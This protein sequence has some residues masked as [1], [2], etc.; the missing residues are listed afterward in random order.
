MSDADQPTEQPLVGNGSDEPGL[1]WGSRKARLALTATILGSGLAFLDGS[2]VSVALPFIERDLGG[3]LATLQWIFD[4]YL[5][6][7]GSLVL[8]GGSLGDLLGKRRI[9]V[10]GTIGFGITS[11]M[12]GLAP[13]AFALVVARML[14]GVAAALLVP[15]SL[16]ILNSVF[17]GPNRGRAIGAWSGLAGLFTAFGPFVGGVLVESLPSGWRWVFLINL[18]LVIGALWLAKLGI[19]NIPGTRT[20]AP[21]WSQVDVLGGILAVVGLGLIVGPLIEVQ[22]L[23]GALTAGLVAL[24]VIILGLFG[25]VEIRRERTMAPPPMIRLSLF[26]LRTFSVAN[27]LTFIVYGA[28]SGAFFLVTIALQL[29]MGYSAIAAGTAGIPVTIMLALFSS[30]VGGLLPKVGARPLLTFGPLC[31]AVGILLLG[32]FKPG[33]SYWVGVLPGYLIFAIGLVF[34]VAPVTATAL[35]NVTGDLSGA[36]SG[37][38]NALARIAGL[39]AIIF[40]PLAG[41]MAASQETSLSTGL[42]FLTGYRTAMIVAAIV[43]AIGGLVALFGF[44]SNDGKLPTLPI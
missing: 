4:G 25:W 12:C 11:L 1:E 44:K 22:R 30:R 39:V 3:G 27:L 14:Q 38:N 18:P 26:R 21:I 2:V 5:L 16:A 37:V 28:L 17:T 7:L 35:A 36:A 9:F 31:M 41:G 33:Q 15:T 29:G 34:V 43:C 32:V 40:L 8:V 19:P 10:I 23:P 6:T 42:S 20:S 24:G 13:T